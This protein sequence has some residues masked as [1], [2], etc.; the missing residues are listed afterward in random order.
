MK[1]ELC[2]VYVVHADSISTNCIAMPIGIGAL[3]P[4]PKAIKPNRKFT[5][6]SPISAFFNLFQLFSTKTRGCRPRVYEARQTPSN[7]IKLHQ[8]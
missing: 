5:R 7:F 6:F 1:I 8:T 3:E 2:E 4:R